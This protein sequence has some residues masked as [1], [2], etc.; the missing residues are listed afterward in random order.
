M[1]GNFKLGRCLIA[2]AA[3]NDDEAA[4]RF[5]RILMV[6]GQHASSFLKSPGT[7][8]MEWSARRGALFYSSGAPR[9]FRASKGSRFRC[10]W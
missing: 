3:S 9:E 8:V 2:T 4:D 7:G 1:V 6:M 10:L 5:A